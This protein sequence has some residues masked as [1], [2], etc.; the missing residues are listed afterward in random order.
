L[1]RDL[2]RTQNT[3]GRFQDGAVQAKALREFTRQMIEERTAPANTIL[4]MGE[5]A[6]TMGP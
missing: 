3:L 4:A 6:A 5:L 2:K 1:L